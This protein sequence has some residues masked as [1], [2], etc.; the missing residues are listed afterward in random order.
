MW[1]VTDPR[2]LVWRAFVFQQERMLACLGCPGLSRS[3]GSGVL[4]VHNAFVT[5][6]PSASTSISRGGQVAVVRY[7]STAQQVSIRS[8]IKALKE[9]LRRVTFT[10]P[11]SV[12]TAARRLNAEVVCFTYSLLW[13]VTQEKVKKTKFGPLADQDRIF[14]NLYGRHDWRFFYFINRVFIHRLSQCSLFNTNDLI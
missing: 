9:C 1:F 11:V 3:L 12:H 8:S 10:P 7:S 6:A 2:E 4:H 13:S 5:R 14:T